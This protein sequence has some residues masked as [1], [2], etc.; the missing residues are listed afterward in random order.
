MQYHKQGYINL[1]FVLLLALSF[2]VGSFF[3]SKLATTSISDEKLKKIFAIAMLLFAF[4]MLFFDKAP[5]NK[6]D[7]SNNK[8]NNTQR[9]I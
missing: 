5:N 3:G 7:I 2:V 1:Q 4:K 8:P 6:A 9:H